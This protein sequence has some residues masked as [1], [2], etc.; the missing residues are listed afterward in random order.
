MGVA[1]P[2]AA[3]ED[4]Y[5]PGSSASSSSDSEGGG[6]SSGDEPS[7]GEGDEAL[8]DLAVRPGCSSPERSDIV[9]YTDTNGIDPDVIWIEGVVI[10]WG[11][12]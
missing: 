2:A 1:A 3:S 7:D 10:A 8:E 12:G 9:G 4:E 6:S 5:S 11:G